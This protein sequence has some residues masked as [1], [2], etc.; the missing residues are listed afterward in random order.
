METNLLSDCL[1]VIIMVQS[2]VVRQI[3]HKN[4]TAIRTVHM[5]KGWARPCAGE[6]VVELMERPPMVTS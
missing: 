6:H 2:V 4:V 1:S 3:G 5:V